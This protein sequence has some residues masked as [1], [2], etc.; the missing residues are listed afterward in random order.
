MSP[1]IRDGACITVERTAVSSLR[2]GDVVLYRTGPAAAVHRII[3]KT[4]ENGRL[5]FVI[6]A[7]QFPE[8]NEFVRAEDVLGRITLVEAYGRVFR[9]DRGLLRVVG[10]LLAKRRMPAYAVTRTQRLLSRIRR[11]VRRLRNP[12]LG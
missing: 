6:R 12:V 1:F 2:I 11:L 8:G 5:Q 7:D 10:L 3:G 4:G 9:I